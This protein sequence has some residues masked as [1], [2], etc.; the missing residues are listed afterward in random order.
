MLRS[1]SA[2]Q[3]ANVLSEASAEIYLVRWEHSGTLE[4][5]SSNGRIVYDGEVYLPGVINEPSIEDDASATITMPG[6]PQRIADSINGTWRNG[7]CQIIHLTAETDH[8]GTFTQE[9]GFLHLD[10]VIVNSPVGGNDIVSVGIVHKSIT[11]RL[12]PRHVAAEFMSDIPVVGSTFT[13][14]GVSV[15][16]RSAAA[17]RRP[18]P[19]ED[20]AVG[21]VRGRLSVVDNNAFRPD[22]SF[23]DQQTSA[24]NVPLPLPYGRVPCPGRIGPKGYMGSDLVVLVPLGVSEIYQVEKVFVDDGPVPADVLVRLYRGSSIQEVDDWVTAAVAAHESKLIKLLPDGVLPANYVVLRF[25]PGSTSGPPS[26][27]AI[28]NGSLVYDP[29]DTGNGDPFHDAVGVSVHFTGVDGS[30]VAVDDGPQALAVTLSGGAQILG[31]KVNVAGSGSV[32][33]ANH[34]AVTL[35]AESFTLEFK[36]T[37]D[38]VSS[39][40][41]LAIRENG[42]SN[43]SF[44]MRASNDDLQL[45]LSSDGSSYDIVAGIVAAGVFVVGTEYDIKVEYHAGSH[46]YVIW[47]DGDEVWRLYST[48]TLYDPGVDWELLDNAEGSI[49]GFKITNGVLRYGGRH[50]AEAIPFSDSD[51]YVPGRVYSDTPALIFADL[52]TNPLYGSGTPVYGL[53]DCR[54]WNKEL[55]GGVEERARCGIL[56]SQPRQTRAHL[57]KIAQLG[58]LRWLYEGDGIRM[59]PDRPPTPD[60]PSGQEQ[61]VDASFTQNL[62]W[63]LGPGCLIIPQFG[64]LAVDGT[65]TTEIEV[66]KQTIAGLDVGEQYAVTIDIAIYT[67]G[68]IRVEIDGFEVIATQTAVGRYAAEF[69]PT[70]DSVLLVAIGSFDL[71]CVLAELSLRRYFWLDENEFG[72]SISIDPFTDRDVYTKL[73]FYYQVPN[74]D[75]ANWDNSLPVEVEL[76][77]VDNGDVPLRETSMHMP[78]VFRFSEAANKARAHLLRTRDRVSMR[79]SVPTRGLMYS[80]GTLVIKRDPFRGINHKLRVISIKNGRGGEYDITAE[81]FSLSHYPSAFLIE[82]GVGSVFD[83]V[84]GVLKP[85]ASIPANYAS[86]WAI[87]S[88]ADGKFICCA[89]P[90]AGVPALAETGGA[91]THPGF[92]GDTS[93]AGEHSG[94]SGEGFPVV[95]FLNFSGQG[96]GLVWTYDQVPVPGHPHS[97]DT[98]V[99]TP[100]LFRR[101]FRLVKKINGGSTVLPKEVMLLGLPDIAIA[102]VDRSTAYQG[103]MVQAS[104]TEQ[105]AGLAN[106]FIQ[107]LTGTADDS[108]DHWTFGFVTNGNPTQI[109]P[110]TPPTYPPLPA[111]GIHAHN[112][113]L[114][115]IA[116]LKKI[117]VALYSSSEDWT[118]KQGLIGFTDKAV[119]DVTDPDWTF[120]DG[121]LGTYDMPGCYIEI[122]AVGTE[123]QKSG[124]NTIRVYGETDP[125]IHKHKDED[126]RNTSYTWAVRIIKHG[127]EEIHFHLVNVSDDWQPPFH[128]LHAFMY[129]PNPTVSFIDVGLLISGG[130]PDGSVVIVDD[131][132][133][134]LSPAVSGVV[135]YEDSQQVFG[136]SMLQFGAGSRLHYA[137]Y[138]F[139]KKFT[140]EGIFSVDAINKDHYFFGNSGAGANVWDVQMR[141][142][143]EIT[144]LANSS[145]ALTT[146]GPAV[147]ELFY[148][149]LCYD[150]RDFRLYYGLVSAGTA[151]RVGVPFNHPGVM[152]E[153]NFYIGN[154]SASAIDFTGFG[155]QIRHTRGASL[156]STAVIPIPIEAFATE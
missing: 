139:G 75:S 151:A 154:N 87:W 91:A 81:L 39:L 15:I 119:D 57:D 128:A 18:K 80:E 105:S 14:E 112:A 19:I 82:P 69:V 108:H 2:R 116:Q 115:V 76:P 49:R 42:S 148:L 135:A 21:D 144:L 27:S 52:A 17:P 22:P 84:I 68:E 38:N 152:S 83:G 8:L 85:G 24:A 129:N 100:D 98:G 145:D 58:E 28:V 54:A 56:I 121:T 113:T 55:L 51:T 66:A 153:D 11:E 47:I 48:D 109:V 7:I 3:Q 36:Y 6:N 124:D 150:G 33:I 50:N 136:L 147:G 9:M 77:G 34:P 40:E 79:W 67:S 146:P 31:N 99:L 43:R 60:S 63:V 143:N 94:D 5:L 73:N 103:R 149:A 13:H 30:T 95:S 120:M 72:G 110:T 92:S 102:G 86:D 53:E 89:G 134:G 70:S 106:Q 127:D 74:D 111:G 25:P 45:G 131:S 29:E 62:G 16:L 156:Y 122:A 78:E 140:L 44:L 65:Q 96:S 132:S 10:G 20:P 90:G 46:N 64:A 23:F 101:E 59:F 4:L 97:Y 133:Y 71:E 125:R 118:S 37:P 130:E 117:A 41:N 126:D 88:D 12:T 1:L 104:A 155:A 142:N 141:A 35:G 107:L 137:S 32:T 123:G 61:A 26:V 93:V 138:K 114:Q